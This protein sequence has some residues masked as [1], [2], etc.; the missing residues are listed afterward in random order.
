MK[1]HIA[2]Y[3]LAVI[4]AFA[5]SMPGAGAAERGEKTFGVRTGYVG[6][7]RSADAGLFFQYAFSSNFRLQPAVDLVFRNRNR[8]AFMVD[9]DAQVPFSFSSSMLDLYPYVGINY[10]SWNYHHTNLFDKDGKPLNPD[11]FSTDVSTRKNRFGLNLGA[12]FGI[13]V[14][15]TLKLS[16]QAGY[17][18]V[19]S[20]SGV[21]ILTGIGYVF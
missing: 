15:P 17:T 20:F 11:I 18:L 10:S 6:R 3:A 9:L 14:S 16:L 2:V 12:G 21:R 19:K 5:C 1:K 4:S 7:N 8:D 13:K